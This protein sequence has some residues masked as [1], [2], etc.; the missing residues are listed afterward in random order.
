MDARSKT[1]T[2][3]RAVNAVGN[4]IPPFLAGQQMMPNLMKDQSPGIAGTVTTLGGRMQRS[5]GRI[6]QISLCNMVKMATHQTYT[7][8]V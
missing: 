6:S 8:Y 7:Y 5:L 2:V 4:K 3:I 1:V